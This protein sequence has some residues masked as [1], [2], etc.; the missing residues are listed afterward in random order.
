MGFDFAS[1]NDSSIVDPLCQMP[2]R[3]LNQI[4][5]I[6]ISKKIVCFDSRATYEASKLALMCITISWFEGLILLLRQE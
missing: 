2:F 1:Q 3:L 5:V 6:G 4:L